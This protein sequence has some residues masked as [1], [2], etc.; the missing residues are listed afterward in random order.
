MILIFKVLHWP[1]IHY[2]I[3]TSETRMKSETP[4]HGIM[5][6]IQPRISS[7]INADVATMLSAKARNIF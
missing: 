6:L 1:S 7:E 5:N 4:Q 2:T 3:I